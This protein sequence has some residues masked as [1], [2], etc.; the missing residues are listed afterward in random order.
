MQVL[1]NY[2]LAKLE[3]TTLFL[4][5]STSLIEH[6]PLVKKWMAFLPDTEA[7]VLSKPTYRIDFLKQVNDLYIYLSQII[8]ASGALGIHTPRRDKKLSG[9]CPI[10]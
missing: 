2:F 7:G 8:L 4:D 3:A 5:S 10:F 9:V 1:L 6:T